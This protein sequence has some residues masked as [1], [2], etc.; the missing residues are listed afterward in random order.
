MEADV[1]LDPHDVEPFG[2][3]AVVKVAK[4]FAHLVEE[5]RS[6]QRR[7]LCRKH[8]VGRAAYDYDATVS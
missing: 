2:A 6:S 5:A 1:R 8:D 4:P 7:W 3:E